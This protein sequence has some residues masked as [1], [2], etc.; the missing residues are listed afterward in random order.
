MFSLFL[1][2]LIQVAHNNFGFDSKVLINNLQMFQ[3]ELPYA[4]VG[5]FDTLELM[6]KVRIRS[7]WNIHSF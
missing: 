3:V 5:L 7:R 2:E 6:K 1:F 4:T